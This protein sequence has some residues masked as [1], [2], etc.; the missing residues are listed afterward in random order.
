MSIKH[1][2]ITAIFPSKNSCLIAATKRQEFITSIN[3]GKKEIKYCQE[4]GET[5]F[6]NSLSNHLPDNFFLENA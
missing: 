2:P 1:K 4:F 5:N 3:F 6:A